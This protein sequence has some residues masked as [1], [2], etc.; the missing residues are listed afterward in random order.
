MSKTLSRRDFLKQSAKF[1]VAST[2][3]MSSLASFCSAANAQPQHQGGDYKALVCILLAGG[4]DSFNLLVPADNVGYQ[5]YAKTRADLALSKSQLLSLNA[6]ENNG[7]TL[8]I[9]PNLTEVQSLYNTGDLAFLANV[10]TL[11]KPTT[12]QELANNTAVFPYGLHSHSDQIDQWQSSLPDVRSGTGWG[13]RLADI[14]HSQ[15]AD[16]TLSMNMTLAGNNLFQ[17][18]VT[19]SQYQLDARGSGAIDLLSYEDGDDLSRL[20]SNAI[21]SMYGDNYQNIFRRAYVKAFNSSI[22]ANAKVSQAIGA[23]AA[24][25]TQFGEDEFSRELLMVA[26]A[27]S[28]ANTL[29]MKRQTFFIEYGGWDHHDD[30]LKN[31]A[32]MVPVLSKGM[33]SLHSAMTEIGMENN[34][35]TFTASDFGR[36]LTSNGKGSDHGWGGN[37]MIMGGAVKGGKVYGQYPSLAINNP[38]DTGR[39]VLLPTTSTD[40]YFAEL[41]L[42]LG[43]KPEQLGS[44]L[45]NISRF[46]DSGSAGGPVGFMG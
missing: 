43:V 23:S 29:G 40:S 18:G 14:M 45:P 7:R 19:A 12:T 32:K 15:N 22:S 38:L 9:H 26:R 37:H 10:G 36:T 2:V 41:A 16:Q 35:T 31:M 21:Q 24:F 44:V 30:V 13:G 1:G 42:W 34:V 17:S 28:A 6:G 11:V 39:G 25:G 8:G 33:A 3:M 4:A 20:S 5:E 46:Y 27:I